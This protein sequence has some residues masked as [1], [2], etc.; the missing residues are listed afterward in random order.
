[1]N[2]EAVDLTGCQVRRIQTAAAG[3]CQ[4]CCCRKDCFVPDKNGLFLCTCDPGINQFFCQKITVDGQQFLLSLPGAYQRNN[5]STAFYGL[6][7]LASKYDFD[8]STALS[9][10]GETRWSARF[11]YIPEKNLLIDGAHNPEGMQA[12]ASALQDYF[13]GERFHFLAGCF[14]D[15]NAEEVVAAFAPLAKDVSFIAFD[16]SGR[17]ICSPAQLGGLLEKYAPGISWREADLAESLQKLT[18]ES[19]I[20]VLCGSLHM[21]GE[22]LELLGLPG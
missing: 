1:M 9:G 19:G 13:P 7:Y 6:K 20:T 14:A 10:F 17:E 16:G 12:L 21:C 4:F 8:F 18:A 22:A 3:R 15:K 5:A 11:Q 2:V